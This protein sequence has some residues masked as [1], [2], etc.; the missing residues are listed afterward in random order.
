[1][2]SIVTLPVHK[3]VMHSR[4]VLRFGF[5]QVYEMMCVLLRF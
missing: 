5:Q 3:Q 1:M 2:L 4:W